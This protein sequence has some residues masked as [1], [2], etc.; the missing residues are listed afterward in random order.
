MLLFYIPFIIRCGVDS[1]ILILFIFITD[2][3]VKSLNINYT[4][5]FHK[6]KER[7]RLLK[8]VRCSLLS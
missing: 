3:G 5:D 6:A 1:F 7:M 2:L 8:C 4:G